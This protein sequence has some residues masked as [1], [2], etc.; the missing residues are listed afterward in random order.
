MKNNQLP[1]A[2]LTHKSALDLRKV[3]LKLNQ[4]YHALIFGDKKTHL[5]MEGQLPVFK[6]L[7]TAWMTQDKE[8]C[9][10]SYNCDRLIKNPY[11]VELALKDHPVVNHPLFDHLCYEAN[12]SQLQDFVSSEAILN[13]EFFDYLALS[14]VGASDLAKAEIAANLWDEAGRGDVAKFHTRLFENLLTAMGLKYERAVLV[15]DLSWEAL[16]GL[17][18]FSYSSIYSYNKMMYYGLLAA[19]EMLDPPHYGKLLQGMQRI[20]HGKNIDQSYYVEHQLIDI[21]HANGWLRKVILPELEAHP[22]KTRE[23]WLGFYLRLNS[24]KRYYD[25]LFTQLTLKQAA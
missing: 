7:E 24:A 4:Y 3:H 12:W 18:L 11:V 6:K 14:L 5:E 22:Q 20:F 9:L 1:F 2:D 10:K 25:R 16:A 19:T 21:E 23:F 17:N 8:E 15:K 13:L